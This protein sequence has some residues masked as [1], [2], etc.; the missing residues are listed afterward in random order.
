[1]VATLKTC[2]GAFTVADP[3]GEQDVAIPTLN[4]GVILPSS[5]D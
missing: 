1:M 5:P 3:M 4:I 2:K